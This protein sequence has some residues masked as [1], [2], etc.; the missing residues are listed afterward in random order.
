MTTPTLKDILTTGSTPFSSEDEKLITEAYTFA[1]TAHKNQKRRSG[2]PY[3]THCLSV[4]LTLRE[5][6]MDA[7]T[8]AAGLLHDVPED[9]EVTLTEIEKNSEAKSPTSSMVLR[10]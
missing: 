1:E 10:S 6:G 5:I 4:G 8:I 7:R 3:V 2:E 9:T